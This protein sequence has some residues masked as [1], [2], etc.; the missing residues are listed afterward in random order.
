MEPSHNQM[1]ASTNKPKVMNFF[2]LQKHNGSQPTKTP[3]WVAHLEEES[4]DK[5]ECI[6]SKDPDGIKDITK[7]FIVCLA[8]AMKDAQQEKCSYH[9]SSLDHFICNCPLVAATRVD[10]HLNQKEGMVPKKGAQAPQGKVIM[11]KVPQDGIPKA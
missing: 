8:R 7:E 9:C 11:L 3:V 1:A 10:L 5:E 2:S 6:D 4:T